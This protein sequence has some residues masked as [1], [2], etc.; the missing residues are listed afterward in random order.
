MSVAEALEAD[1]GD[2][3]AAL[4]EISEEVKTSGVARRRGY[5][6]NVSE[7]VLMCYGINFYYSRQ[8]NATCFSYDLSIAQS[9]AK[10]R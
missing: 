6:P 5:M 1:L 3:Q 2:V 4:S 9:A 8:A 10:E 7:A